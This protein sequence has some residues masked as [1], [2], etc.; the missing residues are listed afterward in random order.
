MLK[1]MRTQGKVQAVVVLYRNTVQGSA[2]LQ[3]LRHIFA[4]QPALM[5]RMP[6]LIYDN[7]PEPQDAPPGQVFGAAVQYRHDATNRGLAAAYS[8]AL[9]IAV[10]E[11]ADWLLLLDQD[12]TLT[13]DFIQQLL[14][15][16]DAEPP[17]HICA[18]VP[19][20]V[21]EGVV[22][23]PRL[24]RGGRDLPVQPGVATDR[25]TVF[26]SAACV[27]VKALLAIGGF[28]PEFPLDYLDH[29]VFHRLQKTDGR[30]Q[31]LPVSIE[32]QL[33]IKNLAEEMSLERYTRLLA[34]EWGFI[35]EVK[36]KGG[37]PVQRVRLLQRALSQMT[38][39]NRSYARR[40]LAAA[41]ASQ[42]RGRF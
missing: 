39:P 33:S 13:G 32:H 38:M 20:Q 21:R 6:L 2:T 42:P 22:L 3:S 18:I 7:S 19:K 36:P 27:R 26:N 12:T 1:D 24:V 17:A 34:A 25:L 29:V 30:L 16:V 28:P 37:A 15:A 23:S 4:A 5:E 31:V 41:F 10:S 35:R 40:T 14:A 8:F 9:D 11:G